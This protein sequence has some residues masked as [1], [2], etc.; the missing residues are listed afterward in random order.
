[1]LVTS[2]EKALKELAGKKDGLKEMC[3][4]TAFGRKIA[5]IISSVIS[6]KTDKNKMEMLHTH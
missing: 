6:T 4:C 1:M 5:K 3:R 2:T